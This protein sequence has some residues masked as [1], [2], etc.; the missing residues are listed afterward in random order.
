MLVSHRRTSST[1]CELIYMGTLFG[2]AALLGIYVDIGV[3]RLR[4]RG[5]WFE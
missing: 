5:A 4:H 1:G 2:R 3:G